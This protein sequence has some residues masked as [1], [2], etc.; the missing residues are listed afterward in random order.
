VVVVPESGLWT[1]GMEIPPRCG[2][3]RL[4]RR[5]AGVVDMARGRGCAPWEPRERV[6]TGKG[7]MAGTQL[8][9]LSFIHGYVVGS[10]GRGS[11]MEVGVGLH[12]WTPVI[13]QAHPAHW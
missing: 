1:A 10:L 2:W 7:N 4:N 5:A 13:Y 6:G 9:S 3:G 8:F 12:A 11:H